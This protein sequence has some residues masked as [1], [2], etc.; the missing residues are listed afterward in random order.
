MPDGRYTLVVDPGA[1]GSPYVI[2]E[3]RPHD[4]VFSG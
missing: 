2:F 4:D 1:G 3:D